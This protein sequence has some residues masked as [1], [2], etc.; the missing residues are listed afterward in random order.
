MVGTYDER[1]DRVQL[2]AES[3]DQG[4]ADAYRQFIEPVVGGADPTI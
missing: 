4:Y 1:S 2:L 3:I